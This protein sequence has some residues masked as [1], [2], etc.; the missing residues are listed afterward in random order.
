[1]SRTAVVRENVLYSSVQSNEFDVI[2]DKDTAER[3]GCN[4][5][6]VI[7]EVSPQNV[8]IKSTADFGRVYTTWPIRYLRR[9]GKRSRIDFYF[10]AGRR[11]ESGPGMF[12]LR[13][14]KSDEVLALMDEFT[15]VL[16]S[17]HPHTTTAPAMTPE[18][19][20]RTFQEPPQQAPT[21]PARQ[22]SFRSADHPN[23]HNLR[24]QQA[25]S[26]QQ[27]QYQTQVQ[28]RIPPSQHQWQQQ[29]KQRT[30]PTQLEHR[31]QHGVPTPRPPEQQQQR[32][33]PAHQ[34]H[35]QRHVSP[36]QRP[37]VPIQQRTTPT[38]QD[39]RA[40]AEPDHP[41]AG[42]GYRTPSRTTPTAGDAGHDVPSLYHYGPVQA[43]TVSGRTPRSAYGPASPES[44]DKLTTAPQL[45]DSMLYD[46]PLAHDAVEAV[47]I[48]EIDAGGLS[49]HRH[50][51]P[52][53]SAEAVVVDD[54]DDGDA[55]G[56][57]G[58]TGSDA[59]HRGGGWDAYSTPI[60]TVQPP[61]DN[62]YRTLDPRMMVTPVAPHAN[63]SV[64]TRVTV[65]VQRSSMQLIA[66][67]KR[68]FEE[69]L[70]FVVWMKFVQW[71]S[72]M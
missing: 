62:S 55:E 13:T 60:L 48:A 26:R 56:D 5:E 47:P 58:D 8:K 35:Q 24:Q 22:N 19:T 7:L 51:P 67:V 9:Y 70:S 45:Y 72:Y 36:T 1:M 16:A 21:L 25:S 6:T 44:A 14:S 2:L 18:D 68:S 57:S 27:N 10:E 59:T 69:T 61:V 33:S 41:R 30:T 4:E 34:Y 64:C 17:S 52:H 39:Q 31:Q 20:N 40:P 29:Q 66:I 37:E 65:F 11:C 38:Q 50:G 23:H 12:L 46:E 3:L 49:Y 53:A 63:A 32:N 43:S 54:G 42:G 15:A 71:T 28:N